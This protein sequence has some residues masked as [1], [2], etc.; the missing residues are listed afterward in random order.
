MTTGLHAITVP[1]GI[2]PLHI[3]RSANGSG[4]NQPAALKVLS[5]IYPLAGLI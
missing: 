4:Y 5:Y 2:A 3:T 1:L